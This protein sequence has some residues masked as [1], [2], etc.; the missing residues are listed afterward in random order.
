[1]ATVSE[2]M[3]KHITNAQINEQTWGGI[4]INVKA[5]GYGAKGDGTDDTA[6]INLAITAATVNGGVVA[7]PPGTYRVGSNITVPS[8]V[9]L[10]FLQ[11]AMLSIDSGV[12]VTINGPIEAG[13]YQIFTGNGTISGSIKNEKVYPQWWGAKING[14]TDDTSA[15]Q[16]ALTAHY[17]VFITVGNLRITSTINLKAFQR[18]EG[19]GE[20]SNIYAD[21][22]GGPAV[23][24]VGGNPIVVRD[25][26]ISRNIA[27]TP[28]D[29]DSGLEIGFTTAWAGRGELSNLFISS[30]FDG[31]KWKGGSMNTMRNIKCISNKRH[32]FF[33]VNPRG[34]LSD[35][36]SSE[37]L[38][39][40]YYIY[41]ESIGETGVQF[42]N[43]GTF[44]NQ[45]FG[46]ILDAAGGVSSANVF[47]TGFTSSFDGRG[48]IYID[49][50]YSQLRFVRTFVEYAGYATN[51]H[52]EFTVYNNSNGIVLGT[53]V[54]KSSFTDTQI[55]HCKGTGLY[56]NGCDDV[57]FDNLFVHDNGKGQLGGA[58]Q[59]GIQISGNCNRISINNFSTGA[60]STTQTTDISIAT[61]NNTGVI[62]NGQ[63]N[64]EFLSGTQTGIKFVN[65]FSSAS[66]SVAS[67]STIQLPLSHDFIDITGTTNIDAIS[68]SWKGRKV[69]LKFNGI[70][71][72]ADGNN[73]RL[74][75][76][77]IT[78]ANDTLTIV[79]DG[80]NWYEVSRS[81]N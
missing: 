11:G 76:E 59:V 3:A 5:E 60:S 51:F 23:R 29:G 37:N 45:E 57:S 65:V 13:L 40:G 80:S 52:P 33:G 20:G 44:A 74:S 38:G 41:A 15:L 42:N 28:V 32:G 26:K 54:T 6:S 18:L 22:V 43:C 35:C 9:T 68:P 77:F 39:N 1:M 71:T 47:C 17:Y 66:N 67:A 24:Y 16:K 53:D 78:K 34:E 36:L 31:F 81:T 27:L 64:S 58:D 75:S 73:L 2:L 21:F 56:L 55:M 25:L 79:C 48:G 70:L 8:N 46:M 61:T 62:S 63:I 7:F 69:T 50:P 12:T 10:W 49:K 72:V 30:H 14:T 4:L 19:E